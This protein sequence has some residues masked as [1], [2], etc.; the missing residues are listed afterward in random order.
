[1]LKDH[2]IEAER[3]GRYRVSRAQLPQA[4]GT[5]IATLAAW[6]WFVT[7]TLR[8]NIAALSETGAPLQNTVSP[9]YPPDPSIHSWRPSSRGF[10]TSGAPQP[11][12]TLASILAFFNEI[13]AAAG[14]P[15]GFVIGEE[16]GRI[17]GRYHCHALL[18]GVADLRRK[19]W[20]KRA[21]QRFGRTR[22][23]PFDPSRA[24]AHY[25]AKYAAKQLGGLHFGGLLATVNLRAIDDR[26]PVRGGR[27]V[28]ARSADVP[29]Q[30]FHFTL[31]RRH[32]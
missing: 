31:G 24:A 16:F 11:D 18:T 22:I 28:V 19:R 26:E 23:E 8:D 10:I 14:Q 9:N 15:I 12:R 7:I 1:M 3:R 13:E 29:S 2:R 6:D 20:W 21:F 30:F 5:F 25:T 17:G 4:F 32:K 27:I